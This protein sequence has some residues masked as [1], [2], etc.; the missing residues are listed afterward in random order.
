MG[1]L[2]K[3]FGSSKAV[4]GI[5]NGIDKAFHTDEEKAEYF[6]T[7]LKAYEPFKL[8]QRLVAFIVTGAYVFIWVMAALLFVSAIFMDPCTADTLCH[9]NTVQL[10]AKELAEWNN[11]TLS[12]PFAFIVAFY[13]GGGAVEGVVA[14]ITDRKK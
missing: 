10:A 7:T 1:I 3:I 13:F 9:S 12:T 2:G 8:S 11:K 6:I 4:D 14:K 5:Y